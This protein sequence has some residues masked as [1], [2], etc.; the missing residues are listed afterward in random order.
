MSAIYGFWDDLNVDGSASVLA[1]TYGTA[2]NRRFVIEWRNVTT[3][4]DPSV[5]FSFE[6]VLYEDPTQRVRLQYKNIVAGTVTTGSSATVGQENATG[7]SAT[8]VSYNQGLLY[9]GLSIR[10]K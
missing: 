7:T 1:D 2:P 5:R 8:Q 3:I 4:T 6:V 9:D 10:P